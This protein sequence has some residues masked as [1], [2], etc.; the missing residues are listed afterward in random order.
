VTPQSGAPVGPGIYACRGAF[1]GG[2]ARELCNLAGGYDICTG[3]AGVDAAACGTRGFFAARPT[4]CRRPLSSEYGCAAE[5]G[6]TSTGWSLLFLGCGRISDTVT[7]AYP[8]GT[9]SGLP[10]VLECGRATTWRCGT[11]ID[12]AAN[13]DPNN[14]VLCCRR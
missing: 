12:A 14:G 6:C 5:G 8:R 11:G 10:T 13:D 2:R 7:Y 4:A 3:G 1:S 9:C